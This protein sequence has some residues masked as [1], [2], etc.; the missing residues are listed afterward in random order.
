MELEY[1]KKRLG[2]TFDFVAVSRGKGV[3]NRQLQSRTLINDSKASSRRS[4]G[5]SA[6]SVLTGFRRATNA[7]KN[8]ISRLLF[9]GRTDFYRVVLQVGFILLIAAFFIPYI[10][11]EEIVLGASGA[12]SEALHFDFG[13]D[14][15]ASDVIYEYGAGRVVVP[16]DRPNYGIE[17]YIVQKGDTLS[18]VAAKFEVN[19][20]TIR[21]ANSLTSDTLRV[22]QELEILPV[23]G[24]LYTVKKG[25]TIAA[26]ANKYKLE[27]KGYSDQSIIDIN[28][29]LEE[30]YT[31]TP[32]MQIIIPGAEVP[33]PVVAKTSTKSGGYTST[34]GGLY[35]PKS[36]GMFIKPTAGGAGRLTQRFHRGHSA[37]DIADSSLPDI[38]AS[39]GGKVIF[40][41]WKS[42]GCGYGVYIDHQNGY[43]TRYCHM[44]KYYVNTGDM[45]K[46][47]Q[48]IGKMGSTGRSTGPHVHFEVIYKG[49]PQNPLNYIKI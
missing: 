7:V 47:G 41:G 40:A 24:I 15:L 42:N 33:K 34:G 39:A 22:G 1:K 36:P 46:Q 13:G 17:K 11:G 19:E 31:L 37:I 45:V 2:G 44:S 43:E 20:D 29:Q 30:P 8:T 38:I 12:A 5:A 10:S 4:A 21:W 25:D 23:D 14:V 49:V 35:V 32:G 28:L 48:R 27:E 16:A 6:R 18:E 3:K 9:W 26:L